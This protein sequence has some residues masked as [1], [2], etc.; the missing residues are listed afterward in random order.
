MLNPRKM[1]FISIANV[2]RFAFEWTENN[3]PTTC[4]GE[5]II[6]AQPDPASPDLLDK[7]SA[8]SRWKFDGKCKAAANVV[9]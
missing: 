8:N 6:T 4:L 5:T 9:N 7:E 1:N 2:P 3:Y